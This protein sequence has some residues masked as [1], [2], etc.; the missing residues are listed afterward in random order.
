MI[1]GETRLLLWQEREDTAFSLTGAGVTITLPSGAQQSPAVTATAGASGTA[2]TLSALCEAAEAGVYT[3]AWRFTAG[4]QALLRPQLRFASWTDALSLARE[5]LNVDAAALPDERIEQA[6]ADT[7]AGIEADYPA[8]GAYAELEA[9]FRRW[10]DRGAALLT[11]AALHPALPKDESS[12]ELTQRRE[13][14]VQLAFSAKS[15]VAAQWS[16]EAWAALERIPA[17]RA[18]REARCPAYMTSV[19]PS[20]S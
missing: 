5:C 13:G 12:P 18:A 14:D 3:V 4:S 6:L 7:V 20:R 2:W 15:D 9:R 8:A 19:R 1:A 16:A 10:F 11:A 17:I